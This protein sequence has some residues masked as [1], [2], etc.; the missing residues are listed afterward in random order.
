[1]P[2]RSILFKFGKMVAFNDPTFIPNDITGSNLLLF[3]S[4]CCRCPK[5]VLNS[6][7][8]FSRI[9]ALHSTTSK[10]KGF[11]GTAN[12]FSPFKAAFEIQPILNRRSFLGIELGSIGLP[13][14]GFYKAVDFYHP[15]SLS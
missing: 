15:Q 10:R 12:H 1:M 14:T 7:I 5:K 13:T 9:K 8:S 11:G 6:K 3:L 2:L 4:T